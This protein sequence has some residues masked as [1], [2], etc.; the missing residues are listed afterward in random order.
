MQ[1]STPT[2]LEGGLDLTFYSLYVQA[3]CKNF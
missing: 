2:F 3:L 1:G